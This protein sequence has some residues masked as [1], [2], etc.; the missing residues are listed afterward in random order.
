MIDNKIGFG[1]A[2]IWNYLMLGILWMTD[3]SQMQTI[4][5]L[6]PVLEKQWGIQPYQKA[7]IQTVVFIGWSVGSILGGYLSDTFG[8]APP[9][10][11]AVLCYRARKEKRRNINKANSPSAPPCIQPKLQKA[12]ACATQ[13][14]QNYAGRMSCCAG[15]AMHRFSL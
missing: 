9:H 13:R 4:G 10:K 14:G 2:Q 7:I 5:V 12:G 15:V 11:Y 8:N 1:A 3:C 6:G